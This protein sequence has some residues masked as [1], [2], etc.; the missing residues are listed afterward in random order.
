MVKPES[1]A[2]T[3]AMCLSLFTAFVV[4]MALVSAAQYSSKA[5]GQAVAALRALLWTGVAWLWR[6]KEDGLRAAWQENRLRVRI[7]LIVFISIILGSIGYISVV[8]IR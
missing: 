6:W 1:I 7:S 2:E 4:L 5:Q 3:V 8:L